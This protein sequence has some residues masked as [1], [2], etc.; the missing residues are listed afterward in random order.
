M[1]IFRLIV[2]FLCIY[3]KK[4]EREFNIIEIIVE[5]IVLTVG[6]GA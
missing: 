3:L 6:M 1:R 2:K 5:Q 4:S